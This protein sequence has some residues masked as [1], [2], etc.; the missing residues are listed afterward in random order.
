M[1]NQTTIDWPLLVFDEASMKA[2]EKLA[3]KRF[4][5]GVLAEEA[6]THV[7]EGLSANDW[8]RCKA[9][10][11]NAKP[12]TYLYS[13]ASNLIE[14]FSRQRFG[15]PRPPTWLQEQGELWVQMWKLLCLERQLLPSILDRLCANGAR[16]PVLVENVA[17]TI[18]ARMP[19]CGLSAMDHQSTEDIAI[20]SDAQQ[21]AATPDENDFAQEGI[22]ENAAVA[23]VVIM[24]RSVL[25]EPAA[26]TDF[27][28]EARASASDYALQRAADM[29]KF[30]QELTLTDEEKILLRMI[31]VDGFS[32]SAASKALGMPSHQAGR[33]ANSALA[34][35][36]AAM[37]SC[38]LSLDDILDNV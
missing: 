2:F 13:L 22:H 37:R 7:V 20:I 26:E 25:A 32:K 21:A 3:T 31:F 10:K 38:G 16:E 9:F 1:N 35:I 11:G 17:R 34:R 6:V 23:E 14:E 30:K 5:E 24:L 27:S 15:R 33:I 28:L 12:T 18:K 19:N 36:G 4:N 29:R 8:A